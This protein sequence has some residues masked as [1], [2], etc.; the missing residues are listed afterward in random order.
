MTYATFVKQLHV[1]GTTFTEA[2]V[3]N[4]SFFSGTAYGLNIGS[5][6]ISIFEYPTSSDLQQDADRISPQGDQ[7]RNGSSTTVVDWIATPHFYKRGRILVLY[8]G[9]QPKIR[10]LLQSLLG[11]QFAGGTPA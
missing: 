9:N 5:E 6:R 2:S 11:P 3:M 7:I 8:I 1:T 10:A 4:A